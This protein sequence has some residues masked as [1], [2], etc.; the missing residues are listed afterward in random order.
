M[1][2]RLVSV[3]PV[4]LSVGISTAPGAAQ[5]VIPEELALALMPGYGFPW[6]AETPRFAVA[7]LPDGIPAEAVPP[8]AEIIGGIWSAERSTAALTLPGDLAE[9]RSA[10]AA[11]AERLQQ[12]GWQPTEPFGNAI[13][14]PPDQHPRRTAQ[15][16]TM[17]CMESVMLRIAT[18]RADREASRTVMRIEVDRGGP[19]GPAMHCPPGGSE[20]FTGAPVPRLRAPDG[21]R[22][23]GSSAGGGE[24]EYHSRMAV[25]TPLD[26]EAL[27]EHFA[28]QLRAEGWHMEE[29]AVAGAAASRALRLRDAEGRD[30]R[31]ML[32]VAAVPG[33]DEREVLLRVWREGMER[34]RPA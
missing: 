30:W 19:A 3:L 29:P 26:A 20:G 8:G 21:S 6:V 24:T 7:A 27:L 31:G 12:S 34:M 5:Q 4:L 16:P 28:G 15:P 23:G 14:P 22:I 17:Y 9:M 2:R 33:F 13:V 11:V 1:L 18:A 32:G 10:L 25:E